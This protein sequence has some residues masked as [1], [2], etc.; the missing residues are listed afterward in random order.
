MPH[1]TVV[2]PYAHEAGVGARDCV[3]RVL[4]KEQLVVDT[5]P[6]AAGGLWNA[7]RKG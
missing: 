4:D 2:D 7:C 1:P 6:L 5:H 3:R